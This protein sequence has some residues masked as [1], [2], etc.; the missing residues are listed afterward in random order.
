MSFTPYIHFQGNCAEAMQAYANIFGATDLQLMRYADAP[1]SAGMPAGN[2][3]KI[4]HAQLTAGGQ[5][6][7]AS[8]WPD[9]MIGAPQASVSVTHSIAD[10]TRGGKIFDLLADGGAVTMPY[11]PTFWSQGFGMVKDRFG[12]HWMIMAPEVGAEAATKAKPKARSKSKA[13]A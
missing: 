9:G 5:P 11:G 1:P 4:M 3:D 13:K 12:T 7:M 8:D 6:L 2:P 10:V